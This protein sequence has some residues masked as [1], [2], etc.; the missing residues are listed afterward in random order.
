MDI[1]KQME[2]F[3]LD[4]VVNELRLAGSGRYQKITYNSL[5]YLDLIAYKEN[6]TVSY[7]AEVLH[8]AKSAVTLKIQELEKLGLVEKKQSNTDKR[9]FYLYVNRTLLEEYKTYDNVLYKALDKLEE[10]F[11]AEQMDI[12]CCML[13]ALNKQFRVAAEEQKGG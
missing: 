4:M 13:E 5:L 11:S 2:R 6:C 9:V 10:A 12:F 8:I 7:L 3:Y 1:K